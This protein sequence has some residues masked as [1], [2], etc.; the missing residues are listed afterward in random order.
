MT[1]QAQ[2]SGY[3]PETCEAQGIS[4]T[5]KAKLYYWTLTCWFNVGI[6]IY[7]SYKVIFAIKAMSVIKKNFF[8]TEVYKIQ[9]EIISSFVPVHS[10]NHI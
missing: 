7:T 5:D 9:N 10:S 2:S 8:L 6:L 1:G 3:Q 4:T